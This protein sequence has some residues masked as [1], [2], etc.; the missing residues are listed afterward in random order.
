[1]NDPDLQESAEMVWAD[2]CKEKSIQVGESWQTC[3]CQH[4]EPQ[5]GPQ[6]QVEVD[7]VP[8]SIEP[9]P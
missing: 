3:R 4:V 5:V 6:V 8:T 7:L 1:M 9:T 2:S